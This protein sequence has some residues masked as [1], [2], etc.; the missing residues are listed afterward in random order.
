M[1]RGLQRSI[2]PRTAAVVILLVI[3][4]VQA[5]WWRAFIWRPPIKSG[6]SMNAMSPMPPGPDLEQGRSDVYV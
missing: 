1:K 5:W 3:A 2:S 6:V 4:G